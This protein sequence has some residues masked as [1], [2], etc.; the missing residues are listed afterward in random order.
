MVPKSLPWKMAV[1]PFP[2]IKRWLFGVPGLSF[3]LPFVFQP[4]HRL[5]TSF[6]DIKNRLKNDVQQK[7][8]FLLSNFLEK[9][10]VGR[11][12]APPIVKLL[13]VSTDFMIFYVYPGWC[14]ISALNS[15][16]WKINSWNLK[17]THWNPE[18]SSSIHP[19]PSLGSKC[20]FSGAFNFHLATYEFETT[21][22]T[23]WIIHLYSGRFFPEIALWK[24]SPFPYT[25]FKNWFSVASIASQTPLLGATSS[26]IPRNVDEK[27]HFWAM[28][29]GATDE[30]PEGIRWV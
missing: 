27:K 15:T 26:S 1:S 3:G 5:R 12:P 17:T 6:L 10:T 14:R 20:S 29:K 16:P 28:T 24:N 4:Y 9:M 19:P 21:K 18:N 22:V 7:T 30:N 13:P 2:S 8:A 11:N 25:L 23:T